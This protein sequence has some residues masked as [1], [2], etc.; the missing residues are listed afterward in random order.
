MPT[1]PSLSIISRYGKLLTAA[2]WLIS[3]LIY[4]NIHGVVTELEATKYIDEAN[5]FLQ[6]GTFSAPRFYFYCVTIF[7]LAFAIKLKL[8]MIGAFVI[9]ASINL[10]AFMLLFKALGKIFQRSITPVLI[11]FYLLAFSPY[12]SWVVFLYTESIFFSAVLILISVLILYK[13]DNLKHIVL[14]TMCLIFTMIS[15][16]LG[17]L[18]AVG[19]YFYLFFN[20]T[21]KWKIVLACSSVAMLILGYFF[22]NSVFLTI[23]DWRITQAFEEESI[24]CDLPA[25]QP[26]QS[27]D[28]SAT[29]S[30]VYQLWYYVTHNFSHF[31]RFAGIKIQYFFLMTRDYYSS[32][33][34]Y[35]L[36]LNVIPVYLLAF[37]S[38]FLRRNDFKRG[39]TVFI[40]CTII[41][42]ALA[43]IFQ[44]DDYHNRF[45][46]SIYPLF[47]LLATRSIEHFSLLMFKNDK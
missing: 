4:L 1:N 10:F 2:A 5:Q 46:L 21:K 44:C 36:L 16:P 11:I 30:P 27:L 35:F 34:N 3:T 45:I 14:I 31:L 9:Q 19:V 23:H 26:Y 28:L 12:Q 25:A 41:I 17:I 29:G 32:L 40:C 38:F 20:A 8:G 24:I 37:C 33:H 13:P 6:D 47:V 39:I 43:I 15:R 7:I 22:I 42:Y 18:F